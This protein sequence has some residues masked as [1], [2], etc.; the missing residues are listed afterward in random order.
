V[1]RTI[2]AKVILFNPTEFFV[3]S[4]ADLRL[5]S[6]A[7]FQGDLLGRDLHFE[8]NDAIPDVNDRS[9]IVNGDP[10]YF[11][12]VY[13]E[14]HPDVQF[15]QNPPA[16]FASITF[17]GVDTMRY[18]DLAQAGG[19]Y[20][21]GD[22]IAPMNMS[23]SS[24]GST[25]GIVFAEGDIYIEGQYDDSLL[26]VAGGNNYIKGDLKA[27]TG[28]AVTPQIGLFAKQ[29]ILI[30]DSAPSS[31]TVEGFLIADGGGSS[32]GQ[33][34]ALGDKFSED[35]F[36]FKGAIAVRGLQDDGSVLRSAVD[37]NVYK[38]RNYL[39]DLSLRNQCTIPFMTYVANVIKWEEIN[40]NDAFPPP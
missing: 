29:D 4:L 27:S 6:G 9:I 37:L 16:Q 34:K 20:A 14:T 35:T 18:R 31:M 1:T 22:Y 19:K 24:I 3:S 36:T 33:V 23:F 38:N 26:F 21:V 17:P 13:G 8:V 28:G 10:Y 32:F 12:N 2:L 25:N 15:M 39:Y 5:T 7:R 11:R 30:P 40:P